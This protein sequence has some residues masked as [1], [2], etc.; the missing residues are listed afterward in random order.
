M[1]FTGLAL[2]VAS[3]GLR[4]AIANRHVRGRLLVSAVIFLAYVLAAAATTYGTLSQGLRE[5][6]EPALPLLLALGVI[7]GLVALAVNPWRSDKLPDR[8]PNILQDTVVIVAFAIA[9]TLILQERIFATTAAVAVVIGFALQDTLGNLFAG[10]AIQIEKPFRVGQWVRIADMDGQVSEIT[11]RAT[12][13]RTKAGNFVVVPNST[14]SKDTITNYS[15]PTQDSRLEVEVGA[16]YDAPPNL[17]KR[18]IMAALQDDP[19]IRTT[20]PPEVLLVDFAASSMTYRVRAWT[21]D[22]ANDEKMR[23]RMRSAIYYAFKRAGITIPYPIQVEYDGDLSPVA[24]SDVSAVETAIR[25]VSI[26]TSLDDESLAQLAQAARAVMYA[27]HEA[28]ARQG[29]SGSSMFVIVRGEAAVVLEPSGQEVARLTD[30]AFFGEMSLLTGAPRNATVRAVTDMDLLEITVDAFRTFVLANPATV[31]TIGVAT[32]KRAA[33]LQQARDA[34]GP[35]TPVEPAGS[36][37]DR[38]RRFLRL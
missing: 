7:T 3:L 12:K 20:R 4:L 26:F 16:S 1:F 22:F 9:A 36:F 21:T 23:D 5:M 13:V 38:V 35:T 11:W 34:D 28:I 24:S 15:E 29:E 25:R 30:G 18:T 17:V 6:L 10:L 37:V 33:E 31:E 2:L 27:A 14:L 32:A 8:F 19:M